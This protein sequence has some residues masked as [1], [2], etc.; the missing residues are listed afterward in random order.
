MFTLQGVTRF[1][2]F[3]LSTFKLYSSYVHSF[4]SLLLLLDITAVATKVYGIDE[5]IRS[6]KVI[7]VRR[8]C[9][10]S[11]GSVTQFVCAPQVYMHQDVVVNDCND[12]EWLP[13]FLFLANFCYRTHS[14]IYLNLNIEFVYMYTHN[15]V[16]G[17]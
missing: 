1:N 11:D 12:V 8:L 2:I 15:N 10:R 16:R 14:K 3:C 13:F 6:N 5:T 9:K 17:M 7:I 4:F